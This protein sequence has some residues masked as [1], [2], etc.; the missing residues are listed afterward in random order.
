MPRNLGEAQK[1]GRK[2][3]GDSERHPGYVLEHHGP[4]LHQEA[5]EDATDLARSASHERRTE[6]THY[7]KFP[8]SRQEGTQEVVEEGAERV[9]AE[10]LE[11]LE[12]HEAVPSSFPAVDRAT[13]QQAVQLPRQSQANGVCTGQPLRLEPPSSHISPPSDIL[14]KPKP[15]TS[16][17]VDAGVVHPE[18]PVQMHG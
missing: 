14:P 18:Q 6:W 3:E 12:R 5:R 4:P 16:W 7:A 10:A 8:V 1:G 17:Q 2:G 9:P 13:T 15:A 11:A